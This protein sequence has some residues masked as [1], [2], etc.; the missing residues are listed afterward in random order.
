VIKSF[1]QKMTF[2]SIAHRLATVREVDN[3][4][5][6]EKGRVIALGSFEDVRKMVPQFDKQARLLGL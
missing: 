6:L 4:I 1:S 5:Y 3:L 2:V